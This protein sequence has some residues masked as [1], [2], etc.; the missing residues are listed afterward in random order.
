LSLS[1]AT[2][3]DSFIP[4]GTYKVTLVFPPSFESVKDL[5]SDV[6]RSS[7]VHDPWMYSRTLEVPASKGVFSFCCA[8]TTNES[9]TTSTEVRADRRNNRMSKC[10][11][12][13]ANSTRGSMFSTATGRC[14][15]R[16]PAARNGGVAAEN[17]GPPTLLPATVGANNCHFAWLLLKRWWPG[18][19]SNR[20]R[21]PFQCSIN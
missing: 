7:A 20:R 1:A 4:F 21:Q 17:H 11:S 2:D 16:K 8:E 14:L 13:K 12:E 5:Q 18:T 9:A 15:S 19:E 3:F 6:E 10:L